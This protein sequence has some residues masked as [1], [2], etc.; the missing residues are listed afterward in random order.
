VFEVLERDGLARIGVLETGHGKV[1]TPVLLPVVN[2]NRPA[3]PPRDLAR[4]FHAEILITNAYILRKEGTRE[5]VLTKGVHGFLDFPGAVMTDSG[6]F[7]SH[8]YGDVDVTNPQIIEFQRAIGSDLG[9]MLDRFSE[10]GHGHARAQADVEETVQEVFLGV[11]T[12]LASFRAEGAFAAWVLGIARRT[13][14]GRFKKKQHATIPLDEVIARFGDLGVPI[15]VGPVAKTGA[16]Y[17]LR[18]VY[19]RDPDGNLVE[20]SERAG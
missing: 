10:P 9:T 17:P 3:I 16:A 20:I 12:G 8:V 2:P 1:A 7:Q 11:F 5:A 19:I 14:A 18:S 4:R 6:A 15:I 13:I